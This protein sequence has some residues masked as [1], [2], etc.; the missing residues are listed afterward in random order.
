MLSG[1]Y[2]QTFFANPD[3]R[4]VCTGNFFGCE[5]MVVSSGMMII[6]SK[7][8]TLV[9][10]YILI[11]AAFIGSMLSI[12]F[13]LLMSRKIQHMATLLVGGIMIGY[14]CSAVTDFV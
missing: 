11:I 9:S 6:F 1:F 14:I 4:T 8:Y 3:R 13:I 7:Y 2:C 10:S 5:S 12:G